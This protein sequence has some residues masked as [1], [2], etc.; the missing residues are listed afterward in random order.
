MS[1][2]ALVTW[3][4]AVGGCQEELRVENGLGNWRLLLPYDVSSV[5]EFSPEVLLF[6]EKFR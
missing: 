3:I 4:W 5:R 2:E 1:S 6:E